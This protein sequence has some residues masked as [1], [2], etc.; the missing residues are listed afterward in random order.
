MLSEVEVSD[1][2]VSEF[3]D[4]KVSGIFLIPYTLFLIPYT[5]IPAIL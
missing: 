5:F 4:L 1:L 2:R 3:Q